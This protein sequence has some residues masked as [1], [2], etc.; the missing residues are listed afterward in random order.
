MDIFNFEKD[1][2]TLETMLL[3][4]ANIEIN[5]L[6]ENIK[7]I[8]A[9]LKGQ[10]GTSLLYMTLAA[11]LYNIVETCSTDELQSYAHHQYIRDE[12][13]KAGK[14]IEDDI[15]RGTNEQSKILYI[16]AREKIKDLFVQYE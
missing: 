10:Q 6:Q 15:N 5:D 2:E 3:K 4:N 11:T 14:I 9:A 16:G 12:L 1:D 13:Q 7:H 8:E